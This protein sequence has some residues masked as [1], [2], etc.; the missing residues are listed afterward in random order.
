[1]SSLKTAVSV[2]WSRVELGEKDWLMSS[3]TYC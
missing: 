2:F 3:S 1:M